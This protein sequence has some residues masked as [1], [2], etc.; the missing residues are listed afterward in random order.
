MKIAV[1]EDEKP[2]RDLLV[3]YLEQWGHGQGKTAEISS[4][5]SAESFWF[6]YEDRKDFDVLF[7][8]IQMKG[9]NGMELAR[10]VRRLDKDVAIVFATGIS[11]GLEEGYELEALHY[12]RKPLSAE[13]VEKCMERACLRR[14]QERFV[15]LNGTE[16][17]VR[18]SEE[19][20]NYVEARGRNCC[21]GRVG[22]REPLTVKE[23]LWELERM[24]DGEA[25]M[26]CHRSYLCRVGNIHRITREDIFFDDGSS[27]PVSR[28]LY[29][30]VNQ[31]FIAC[32][33][34]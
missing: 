20:I 13:K 17:L 22:E 34:R 10:R 8:D 6:A 30:Q 5:D 19:N 1:I 31:R 27:I 21:I 11:D 4:Y 24:L 23:S 18:L 14:R 33:R 9:M 28:R 2:H 3:S 26:K 15:V 7:L 25:F 16:G 32:F 12:L 29:P